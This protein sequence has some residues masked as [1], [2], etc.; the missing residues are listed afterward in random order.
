MKDRNLSDPAALNFLER[1]AALA[2]R[3]WMHYGTRTAFLGR[4][5]RG[6]PVSGISRLRHLFVARHLLQ[7]QQAY[8]NAGGAQSSAARHALARV[9]QAHRAENNTRHPS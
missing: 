5:L 7:R 3:S 9:A 8:R 2:R 4:W 6:G 1:I